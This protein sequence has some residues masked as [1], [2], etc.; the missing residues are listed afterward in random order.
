MPLK[1]FFSIRV[2][3]PVL[4]SKHYA[5]AIPGKV[6]PGHMPV[7][8]NPQRLYSTG[9]IDRMLLSFKVMTRECQITP[10]RT[11]A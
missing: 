2:I 9:S 7:L 8:T 10:T 4:C 6:K 1:E 11:A 5:E 3:D